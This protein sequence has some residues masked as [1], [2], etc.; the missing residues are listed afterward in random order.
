MDDKPMTAIEIVMRNSENVR[1]EHRDR[2]VALSIGAQMVDEFFKPE[3]IEDMRD[4]RQ[5]ITRAAEMAAYHAIQKERELHAADMAL[6][7]HWMETRFLDDILKP[8]P[9]IIA[10]KP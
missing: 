6:M 1:I 2:A 10:P 5:Q 3:S 8:R 9:P 7:K 4:V